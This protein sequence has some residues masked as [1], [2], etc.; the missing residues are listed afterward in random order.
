MNYEKEIQEIEERAYTAHSFHDHDS[1]CTYVE[2]EKLLAVAKKLQEERQSLLE[3]LC[4]DP[5]VPCSERL[6][7]KSGFYLVSCTNSFNTHSFVTEMEYTHEQNHSFFHH[8]G[9]SI[10]IAWMLLPNSFKEVA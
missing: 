9:D 10:V 3:Y 4:R 8:G 1:V 2:F 6:P 7:T 5:W